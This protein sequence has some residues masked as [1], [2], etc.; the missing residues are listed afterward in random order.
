M[1]AHRSVAFTSASAEISSWQA[2]VWPCSVATC[3]AVL[4]LLEQTISW[5]YRKTK[6]N[7]NS[8]TNFQH[9]CALVCRIHVSFGWNQQPASCRATIHGSAMQSG[10]LVTRTENQKKI[11]KNKT[12]QKFSNNFSTW[13]H[14]GL[15]HSRQLRLKSAAG[16]LPCDHYRQPNAERCFGN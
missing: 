16:K 14:T 5:K 13:M 15:S 9:E 3:K 1:N 7:K 6:H 2:A 12:Q 11:S 10:A 8:A 4:W